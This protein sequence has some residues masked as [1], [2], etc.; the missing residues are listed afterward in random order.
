MICIYHS[1]DLDGYTSGA[2][3]KKRFPEARLIGWDYGTP[4]PEIPD[5][6]EVIMIDITFPIGSILSLAIGRQLTIIDHHVSFKKEY[7]EHVEIWDKFLYIYKAGIAACELGWKYLFREPI[8]WAITLLGQYDTWRENGTAVWDDEI[9]PFQYYMRSICTS[10]ES[11]PVS[12]F[13]NMQESYI[14]QGMRIGKVIIGYISV[15]NAKLMEKFS[16]ERTFKGLR[17]ICVNVAFGSSIIFLSKWDEE[18][19][20]IMMPFV[21]NGE[22]YKWSIYTTIEGIDCSELAKQMGGGG[23]KQAAGFETKTF[24]IWDGFLYE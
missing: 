1:N 14:R 10:P 12:F 19:Y 6:E 16:F 7:D 23:H 24:D 22:F 5:A 3:V 8:P 17:A 11:F 20:D 2:I 18:K 13:E 9:L 21:Y 4:I 15:Q